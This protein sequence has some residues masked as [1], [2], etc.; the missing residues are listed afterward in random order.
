MADKGG[1]L[2]ELG[3]PIVLIGFMG[4]GKSTAARAMAAGFKVEPV[5]SDAEIESRTGMQISELFDQMGENDFR[6][7]EEE[8]VKDLV[9]QGAPL[10]SL[11]G[12]A[13]MS[14]G[15]REALADCVTVYLD[16]HNSVCWRRVKRSDRPLARD[17]Q[18]FKELHYE[19]DQVYASVADLIVS[20]PNRTTL[21]LVLPLVSGLSTGRLTDVK[22]IWAS[23][24][25]GGYPVF[26][27][28]GV[29]GRLGSLWQWQDPF[30][31]TDENVARLYREQI[32]MEF[33]TLKGFKA[34][35]PG[36]E[37]KTLSNAEDVLR[38]MAKAGVDRSDSVLAVGGGVVGDLGG[39]CAATYQRGIGVVHVPTTLVA[40]V[41]SAF[42]G[43]TGVDLPEAKNYM[44]SFH[45]PQAVFVDPTL[46]DTLPSE[47]LSAG[48]A[49]V[50]KTAL[51]S[52]GK[53]WEKVLE[54]GGLSDVIVDCVRTKLEVVRKDEFDAG[55][56]AVLNLGHT[57]GHAIE[58]A[59]EY[60]RYRHGEAVALGL[61]AALEISEQ[62][63][64]LDGSIKVRVSGLLEQHNLPGRL[65]GV[66]A[67]EVL[68]AVTY[69]KKRE[70]GTVYWI[71]LEA[72]GRYRV[73][74]RVPDD[75]VRQAVSVLL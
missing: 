28:E 18:R 25:E 51:I 12:G 23:T 6:H 2:L 29:V 63:C 34:I 16:V 10:I 56:R 26:Y 32:E 19:R 74:E 48:Y 14:Q 27:G 45:Q 69:D 31:V 5:D 50:I 20:N 40:Q 17:R 11:G 9:G 47:E 59:T 4:A 41:D 75:L 3:R 64:G 62:L 66:T 35:P 1:K 7:I 15:V 24:K 61:L 58:A 67:D 38:E 42:G 60:R 49:E 73:R 43:K 13:V 52:G 71:L 36:E 57:V 72:P 70:G 54:G 22:A 37:Q 44:G 30:L 65:E 8:V 21:K 33:P 53:L 55:L 46:L 68:E 39:F